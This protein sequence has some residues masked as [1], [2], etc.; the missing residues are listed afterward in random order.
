DVRKRLGVPDTQPVNTPPPS[1][2]GT[3]TGT[4]GAALAPADAPVDGST[5]APA[6]P[7][8]STPAPKAEGPPGFLDTRQMTIDAEKWH[9]AAT[10]QNQRDHFDNPALL[11][12]AKALI[13]V[14]FESRKSQIQLAQNQLTKAVEDYVTKGGPNGTGATVRPSPEIWNQLTFEKQ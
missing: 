1:A 5:A 3:A 14:Q 10:A 4:T 12:N 8:T 7:P 11:A 13:D 2:S 6:G 9:I